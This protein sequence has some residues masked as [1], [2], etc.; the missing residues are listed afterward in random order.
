MTTA[1]LRVGVVLLPKKYAKH[2]FASCEAVSYISLQPSE[3]TAAHLASLHI[4]C[5]VHKLSD[6]RL[7]EEEVARIRDELAAWNGHL[8]DDMTS[9]SL[10]SDRRAT[11]EMLQSF[12]PPF[13]INLPPTELS[14]PSPLRSAP[15]AFPVIRK[16]VAACSRHDAHHM[17]LYHAPC[18]V[19]MSVEYILQQYIP[20]GGVLYK[21][22]LIG[23][24]VRVQLR[25]SLEASREGDAL[26]F[27][28]QEMRAAGP[29]PADLAKRAMERFAALEG[30]VMEF[31]R[32][33]QK[34]LCLT[35]FGW[36]LIIEETTDTP[37]IIDVNY[38][39][40]FD[41]CDFITLL[42]GELVK[43]AS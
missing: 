39:P 17:V 6:F 7:P 25:P 10:L 9:V 16:P 23:E 20:H 27:N 30:R 38:F 19:Q 14:L 1:Q 29:V 18:Q 5:V 13:G 8:I 26:S 42:S 22:Y 24:E 2:Q 12:A 41:E 35:L 36:D 32:A 43:L 21:I 11:C 40:G 34:H 37:Y 33:L 28:S 4:R 15:L 3:L 31:T